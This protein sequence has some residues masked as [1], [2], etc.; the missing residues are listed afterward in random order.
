VIEPRDWPAPGGMNTPPGFSTQFPHLPLALNQPHQFHEG[1]VS[2]YPPPINSFWLP[3]GAVSSSWVALG[4]EVAALAYPADFSP[5]SPLRAMGVLTQNARDRPHANKGGGGQ[6]PSSTF[7]TNFDIPIGGRP[8]AFRQRAE[9][10]RRPSHTWTSVSHLKTST[11]NWKTFGD[12]AR[13]NH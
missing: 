6:K 7:S 5:P 8:A 4:M 10:S 3:A 1:P 9:V 2:A 12:S 13:K 11:F